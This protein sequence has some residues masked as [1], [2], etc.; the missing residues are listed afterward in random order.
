MVR[1]IFFDIDGT[2]VSNVKKVYPP[3]IPVVLERL[4]EKGVKVFIATGRPKQ[5]IESENLLGNLKFDAYIVLNG[6]YCYN[7][8]ED[9]HANPIHPDAVR[10]IADKVTKEQIPCTFC[11]K[12]RVYVNILNERVVE[13]LKQI[14]TKPFAQGD[15][16]RAYE[17]PI[18]Q[19]SPYVSADE[20]FELPD[21]VKDHCKITRWCTV[22]IDLLPITGGKADGIDSVLKYYGIPLSD[23]MA[24]GD[25]DNDIEM[26]KHVAIGVALG[27][28]DEHVKAAAD[29]VT[30][31]VDD[32]GVLH[33]LE[34][35]GVI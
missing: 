18:F 2:L 28:A 20:V 16:N 8:K 21:C 7:E 34:H 12:D 6:Q 35:F 15:V 27:N 22:G 30:D 31:D 4:R 3:S 1:A 29:Y 23:T 26:R 32:D 19:L 13:G 17:Q 11:E 10:A 24:F 14:H 33:A 9:I 25:G 5:I